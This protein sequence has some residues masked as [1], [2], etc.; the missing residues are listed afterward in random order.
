MKTCILI[1]SHLDTPVKLNVALELLDF[2]KISDLPVIFTGNFPLPIEIQ[3][4]CDWTLN[5][6]ENPPTKKIRHTRWEGKLYTCWGYAHLHQITNGFLLGKSLGFDYIHHINYD[7]NFKEEDFNKI[8]E[9]G[10]DYKPLVYNWGN[11]GF[12]TNLFSIKTQDYLDSIVDKLHYY[13]NENP[14]GIKKGWICETFFQW[15]LEQNNIYPTPTTDI[16]W[17]ELI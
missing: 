15:A 3:E 2:L 12:A 10:K 13:F 9:H 14:P 1:S 6:K 8:I 5:I 11:D 16:Q 7:I 4:K 17:R